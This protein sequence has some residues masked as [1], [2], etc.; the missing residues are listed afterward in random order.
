MRSGSC[1]LHRWCLGLVLLASALPAPGQEATYG[2]AP[3]ASTQRALSDRPGVDRDR[4]WGLYASVGVSYVKRD[5]V[6]RVGE[7]GEADTA[8]VITPTITYRTDIG[9]HSAQFTAG[10]TIAR[11]DEF[12]NEDFDNYTVDGALQLD[13]TRKLDADLYAGY[14]EGSE[15]RGASGTRV[16]QDDQRDELE[17]VSYGGRVIYGR[18]TNKIQLAVG[19]GQSRL[20]YQNNS[21][22]IRDRNDDYA[23]ATAYYNVGPRTSLFTGVLYREFDYLEPSVDLDSDETEYYVGASWEATARTVGTVRIGRL[24]KGFS[25]PD[26][27]DFD[28][29]T[30]AARIRWRARPRTGVTVYASRRTEETVSV[31]DSFFVSD[32]IGASIDHTFTGRVRGS[33]YFN[34]TDDEFRSGR[35]DTIKD[36]GGRLDY[37]LRSWLSVGLRYSEIER[38]SND[39]LANYKDS[40]YGITLRADFVIA[41]R[42]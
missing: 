28:G 37:A 12:E 33:L 22:Q 30:Y 26:N 31:T 35:N 5:N 38:E 21:Q 20:R 42:R 18:R 24:K 3:A 6:G 17:I 8:L 36:Y 10:S 7:S 32:L 41:G 39:L 11:Y 15:E 23:D 2:I 27:G 16:I 34:H 13:L 14:A 25:N 4:A 29:D 1:E 40:V 19:A 9:R